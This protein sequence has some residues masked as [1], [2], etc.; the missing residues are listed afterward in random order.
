MEGLLEV[1]VNTLQEL[2]MEVTTHYLDKSLIECI[3]K[4]PP[5]SPLGKQNSV[6]VY[7]EGDKIYIKLMYEMESPDSFW[8]LFETNLQ[9]HG[10]SLEEIQL[11]AA[12]ITKICKAIR[13]MNGEIDEEDAW[14]F[15]YNYEKNNKHLPNENDIDGIAIEYIKMAEE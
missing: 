8:D 6:T 5:G 2:G 13:G 4:P 15:L 1:S 14:D 12:I 11:K 3:G 9:I 7:K 10:A